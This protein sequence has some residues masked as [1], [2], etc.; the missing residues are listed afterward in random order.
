[1]GWMETR[2]VDERMRF[3]MAVEKR[4]ETF[5]RVLDP[6]LAQAVKRRARSIASTR[7]VFLLS[8]SG[9]DYI[10]RAS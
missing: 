9:C 10:D 2:V 1:M 4:E 7:A 6:A 5:T 3:M 8:T